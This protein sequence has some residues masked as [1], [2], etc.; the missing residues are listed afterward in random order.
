MSKRKR[1]ANDC[2]K[3]NNAG[4]GLENKYLP[5]EEQDPD[6]ASDDSA[7]LGRAGGSLSLERPSERPEQIACNP[8]CPD[9]EGG[10]DNKEASYYAKK[11]KEYCPEPAGDYA[12]QQENKF[13]QPVVTG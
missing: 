7:G 13:L 5:S 11:G 4:N 1:D 12:V 3:K 9:T 8:K 6:K 2:A 10:R